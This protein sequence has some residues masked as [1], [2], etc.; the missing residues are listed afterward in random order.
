MDY[1]QTT[2][3]S[4]YDAG[5]AYAPAALASWL[6]AIAAPLAGKR[7]ANILDLGC[8]TGR[9]SAAL[10]SHFGAQVI[11]VDPSEKMLAEAR[12]KGRQD[13]RFVRGPGE[14]LPLADASVDMV[15]MSMVFHHFKNPGEVAKECRRALRSDGVI[16]LR[17]A[18][19]DCIDQYPYVSFFPETRSIM[20]KDL[21][22]AAFIKA[23]FEKSG[24]RHAHHEIVPSTIAA[25]WIEYAEKLSFRADS[26]LVQL[27]DDAFETG[28][29][30]LRDHARSAFQGDSV[31]EP[32][33]FFVF[34]R[35]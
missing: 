26:I 35:E 21:Q 33:D 7:I 22:S 2:M 20:N 6:R 9:Y 31:V 18:T 10:A 29:R 28:M 30:A 17:A 13:V 1:D 11:G 23:A 16:C 3:P 4:A 14:A 19:T 8:G 32:V 15:F 27:R 12:Q 5:R 25:S 24:F 34:R